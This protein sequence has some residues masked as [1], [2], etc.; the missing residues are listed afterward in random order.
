MST[1]RTAAVAVLALALAMPALAQKMPAA[2]MDSSMGA[3][4]LKYTAMPSMNMMMSGGAVEVSP[5]PGFKLVSQSVTG[6]NAT[7]VF[8]SKDSKGLFDFYNQAIMSEGW[9]QDTTMKMPRMSQGEYG[10]AYVMKTYK[11]DLMSVSMG[12]LTTVTLKTH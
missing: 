10:E 3:P 6:H 11:L 4:M 5:A 1:T 12:A 9:K 2:K 7:L 8:Q